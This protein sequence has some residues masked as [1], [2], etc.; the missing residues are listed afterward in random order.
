MECTHNPN[1]QR[2]PYIS[3]T[4]ARALAKKIAKNMAEKPNRSERSDAHSHRDRD[5]SQR[6]RDRSRK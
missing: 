5:R 3:N 1:K 4:R 2:S 6:D